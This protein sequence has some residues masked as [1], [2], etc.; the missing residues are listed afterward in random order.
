MQWEICPGSKQTH[1]TERLWSLP[2]EGAAPPGQRQK[3]SEPCPKD[4]HK[5]DPGIQT[6]LGFAIESQPG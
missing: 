1:I 4:G 5:V 6:A 2:I 3:H